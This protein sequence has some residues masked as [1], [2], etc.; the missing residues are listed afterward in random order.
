MKTFGDAGLE[1]VVAADDRLVDLGASRHVVGLDGQHLLQRVGRAVSL[2]RPH[3]HFAEALAAELGLA[4][5]RL[6]GDEAVGPID[7][8]WILSSTRWW[9]F[10]I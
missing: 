1:R 10:S 3:L 2:E 4:A 5:E 8:A 7:R 9:S 6:L